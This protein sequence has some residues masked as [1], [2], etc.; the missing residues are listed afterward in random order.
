MKSFAM[1]A[2]KVAGAMI[3]VELVDSFTGIF[4]TIRTTVRGILPSKA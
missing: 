3:V 2:L 4:T 1:F